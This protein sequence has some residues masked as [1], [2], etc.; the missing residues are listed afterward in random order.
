MILNN[1]DWLKPGE[2]FPPA[3][4][5]PRMKGYKDNESLFLGDIQR[6]LGPY[7]N[8]LSEIISGVKNKDK[9]SDT[10]FDAPNYWQLITIKTADM[11]V[12]ERPIIKNDKYKK[13]LEDAT[14]YSQ[15]YTK[16]T[17]IVY[18]IDSLGDCITVPYIDNQGRRTFT[19]NNPALWIP[20]VNPENVKDVLYDCICWT[21]CVKQDIK[22]PLNSEYELHC[23][24]Q[25]RGEFRYY[26]IKFKIKS[27]SYKEYIHA[28]TN[29][30]C[31]NIH[32]FKIGKMISQEEKE[33]VYHK[34]VIHFPGI[35][36]SRNI[37]GMSNYDRIT[38][39]VGEIAIREA[40]ANY[41]LDENSAP[42]M[43]AGRGAFVKNKDGRWVLKT[44]GKDFVVE[45]GESPPIYI[46][47][48]GNLTSNEN[49]IADL[50]REL[51]AMSEMGSLINN[52]DMNSS[53]GYDALDIKLTNP[54]L[55]ARRICNQMQEPLEELLKFLIN[56]EDDISISFKCGL[57]DSKSRK[58]DMAIKERT[59][60]KSKSTIFQEYFDM[61]EDD[62][63]KE[64][65]KAQ[66]ENAD[67][68]MSGFSGQNIDYE[69]K[70]KSVDE[71]KDDVGDERR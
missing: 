40:L 32:F 31:G 64:V 1:F 22:Y 65:E 71:E 13:E 4:E 56:K 17:E 59:I 14:K 2:L 28:E 45:P 62:A 37:F 44:G 57:P 33:S 7:L 66:E 42:R 63:E 68:F 52:D 60:G 9:V 11:A 34:A 54:K 69:N 41:I 43:A 50:K 6:V 19:V 36:T 47:W 70:S 30:N 58:L 8:R 53:Q 20:V 5:I 67:A 61:N 48:D 55:K 25:K 24:I 27:H 16:L 51:Y 29:E 39:I 26:L 15:I 46:T 18:D 38:S 49:R 35:T 23:K 21:V 12:G 10:F 3:S